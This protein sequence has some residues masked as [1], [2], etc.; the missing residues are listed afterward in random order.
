MTGRAG[1]T[2]APTHR[3]DYPPHVP[4]EN[5]DTPG[6]CNHCPLPVGA[7]HTIHIRP[8]DLPEVDPDQ[9]DAEARRQGEHRED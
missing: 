5:P 6:V 9:L 3:A 1:R 4:T 7:P 2:R 8:G